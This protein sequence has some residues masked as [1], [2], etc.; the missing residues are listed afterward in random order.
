M[1]ITIIIKLKPKTLYY[2]NHISFW[3]LKETLRTLPRPKS[4]QWWG[5][6]QD[7]YAVKPAQFSL[8]SGIPVICLLINLKEGSNVQCHSCTSVN[9]NCFSFYDLSVRRYCRKVSRWD[10]L[11]WSLIY[12]WTSI[13]SLWA[14][15]RWLQQWK[16]STLL[17][18]MPN[19]LLGMIVWVCLCVLE[20]VEHAHLWQ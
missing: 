12:K 3:E 14:C 8:Q 6:G 18:L 15:N 4:G 17:L 11:E 2:V 5:K 13:K 16:N 1:Y 7:M 9:C 10:K 20:V 19:E